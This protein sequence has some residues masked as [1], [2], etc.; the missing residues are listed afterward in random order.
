MAAPAS[1]SLGAL[2][3]TLVHEAYGTLLQLADVYAATGGSG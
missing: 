2:V 3:E 1:V